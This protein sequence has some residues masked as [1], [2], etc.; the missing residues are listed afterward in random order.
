[1]A[2]ANRRQILFQAV[3]LIIAILI[4]S[5]WIIHTPPGLEGKLNAVGY[6]VCHQI[7]SHSFFI[8]SMQF[9]ICSRCM[10]M[11]MGVFL[12]VLSLFLQKSQQV[13]PN[14]KQ[15]LILGFFIAAWLVDGLNSLFANSLGRILFYL[16]NN[17]L[18]FITGFGM[19]ICIAITIYYLFN[20]VVWKKQGSTSK[21]NSM[22]II[23]L[24]VACSVILFI[25]FQQNE[26]LMNIF[27]YISVMTIVLLLTALYSVIWILILHKENTFEKLSDLL[28]P[29]NT[30]FIFAMSQIIVLDAFRLAITGNWAILIK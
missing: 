2:N 19:G 18:R 22:T 6:S 11:Y 12:G 23:Y 28:M 20:Y 10:G 3:L 29:I 4:I 17:V 30:G 14:N 21:L 7:S 1:M 8:G 9:P 25:V 24:V 13:L 5:F 16:P 26:I 27:S 15:Y